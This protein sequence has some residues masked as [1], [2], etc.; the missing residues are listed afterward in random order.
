MNT[1]PKIRWYHS[2]VPKEVLKNLTQRSDAKGCIQILSQLLITTSA[3]IITYISFQKF[4]LWVSIPIFFIYSTIHSF[5]GLSGAGHELC[6]KTV[7]KTKFWNEFFMKIVAFLSWTDYVFFRASHVR[8]HQY[9]VHKGLDLEVVLPLKFS[10]W[11]WLFLFTFNLPGLV[12]NIKTII[13]RSLGILT[14]EWELRLYPVNNKIERKRLFAWSRILLLGHLTLAILFVLSGQWTLLLLITFASYFC[15]WLNFLVSFPQHVGLQPSVPDFRLCCR[16]VIL[17]PVF[18]Y[19]YWQMNYHIEHHM[20]AGVPFYNLKKLHEAIKEDCSTPYRGL[21]A[22][23]K[24]MLMIID[25][26]RKDPSYFYV[27]TLPNAK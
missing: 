12:N 23:W 24:D 13:R 1:Q 5:L 7:F 16:T 11:Q 22:A 9:T 10:R 19:F 15:G 4:S 2:P 14:T 3:G 17:N 26:Q 8:H 18:A 25:K 20:Y 27:P 6:H 21:R